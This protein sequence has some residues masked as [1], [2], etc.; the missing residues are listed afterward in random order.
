MLIVL[1]ASGCKRSSKNHDSLDYN[2][3]IDPANFVTEVTNLLFPLTPGTLSNYKGKT[4]DGTEIDKV[5]VTHETRDILGVACVVVADSVWLEGDLIEATFDWY[6]QDTDGNVWYFGEDSKQFEGGVQ[7]GT[8]G[9]WEAGAD[10]A[11][12]GIIMEAMPKVGGTYRQEFYRA[13]AEDMAEVLG[14]NER[15][16][17]PYGT[18]TNCLET[19]EWS[20]LEPDIVANK[21]YVPG[22]GC[23]LEVTVQGG[24]ERVELI[25]VVSE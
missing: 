8:E 11:K 10:G 19:K 1:L 15:V 12:P 14:L 25:N 22:I 24:S 23:V 6:A 4:A 17:V 5:Y 18:F 16:T 2:P 21:Y 13:V 3:I 9:S 20:P 7:A